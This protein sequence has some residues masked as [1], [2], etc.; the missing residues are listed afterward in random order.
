MNQ[1]GVLAYL[2]SQFARS[3][4]DC[5]TEALTFLLQGCPE[6]R[7]ALR[8][9]V[10]RLFQVELSP[11]LNYRS[12]V[13]DM[14]TGRPDVVGTDP[15]GADQLV[16]EA[17][18]WAGLTEKQPG[19]YL[20]RLGV[21]KPGV[22]LAVAPAARLLTLWPELLANLAAY[23]DEPGL[24]A[25]HEPGHYELL[26]PS[27]HVL[28][29]RSWREMLG[30]LDGCLRAAGLSDWLADLAQLRGLTER[31]DQPDFLPLRPQDLDMRTARQIRSLF[32]L[33]KRLAGEFGSSDPLVKARE[34]H[35]YD[36]R[37]YVGWW[38][39]S[40]ACGIEIWIGLYFD[41]WAT[42]GCSPLWAAVYADAHWTMQDL[43]MALGQLQLREG[44]GRWQDD[45]DAAYIVP[46]MLK[47]SAVEDDVVADLKAQLCAI[48]EILDMMAAGAGGSDG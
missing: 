22:V 35:S 9:F 1:P 39:K 25:D 2:S 37:P 7:E 19:G 14:E 20:K 48:A 33:V 45:I 28:A 44:S 10:R 36:P 23:R 13:T 40:K 34:K 21:G 47:R 24:T 11:H 26:L 32:P 43:Y 12:Q 41:A 31:M 6:V 4:E 42:H 8:N 5:A 18:F 29:L 15:T 17:K 30:E 16:I 27:G 3:E 46:L 38:L